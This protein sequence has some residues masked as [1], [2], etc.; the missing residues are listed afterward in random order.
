MISA[1]MIRTPRCSASLRASLSILT[2]NASMVAN[3]G[4]PFSF[5]TDAFLT[6]ILL[7][8]PM[9]TQKTGILE[10]LR[11]ARRA[12][13]EPSVD[14]MTYTPLPDRSTD[15]NMSLMSAMT[16]S[17]KSSIISSSSG[18]TTNSDVPATAS[19]RPCA[20][21]LTPIAACICLWWMYSPLTRSSFSGCGVRRALMFVTIGPLIPHT[22][23]VSPS[24]SVPLTRITSIVVPRPSMFLTSRMVHCS[25][26]LYTM[27]L[28]M[29]SCVS[30]TSSM[31]RSGMPSPV[32]A[33]VGATL[34][35]LRKSGLS[36]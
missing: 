9:L 8:V 16:S 36:Q 30:L 20:E 13:S 19:S 12:S 22:M 28:V 1:H 29:M 23:M 4:C 10:S 21:I 25:S 6:S 27:A 3:S 32:M 34:T 26:S 31:S 2:S 18:S 35:F 7:T 11:K 24:C 17:F 14:A 15:L 5:I 33:L